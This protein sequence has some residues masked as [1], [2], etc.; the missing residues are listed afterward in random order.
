MQVNE[1]QQAV[2][3]VVAIV[4]SVV[5]IVHTVVKGVNDSL[6]ARVSEPK[7]FIKFLAIT[8]DVLKYF[9]GQRA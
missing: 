4:T 8:G 5:F 1:I 7:S 3:E 6:A 2:T 9:I